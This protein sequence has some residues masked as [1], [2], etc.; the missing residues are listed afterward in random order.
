MATIMAGMVASQPS[1]F[2]LGPRRYAV[3]HERSS[4]VIDLGPCPRGN[5]ARETGDERDRLPY[6]QPEDG[7]QGDCDSWAVDRRVQLA[8]AL[9]RA[10]VVAPMS[11]ITP[12]RRRPAARTRRAMASTT[13]DAGRARRLDRGRRRPATCSYDPP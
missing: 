3:G 2:E 10:V 5:A 9:V 8:D 13:G 6:G 11:L 1:I 12:A 4:Q 7:A